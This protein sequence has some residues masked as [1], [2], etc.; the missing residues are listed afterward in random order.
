MHIYP[1]L[2]MRQSSMRIQSM[3]RKRKERRG[4]KENIYIYIK[5]GRAEGDVACMYVHLSACI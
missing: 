2:P 3:G 5:E 4:K 1:M